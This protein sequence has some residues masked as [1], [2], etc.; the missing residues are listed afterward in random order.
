MKEAGIG[1][2][3]EKIYCCEGSLDSQAVLQSILNI[4]MLLPGPW[5]CALVMTIGPKHNIYTFYNICQLN[6]SLDCENLHKIENKK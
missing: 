6:V 4:C 1:P 5:V 3:F 2:F